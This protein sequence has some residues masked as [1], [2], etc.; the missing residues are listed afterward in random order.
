MDGD[1]RLDLFSWD[2]YRAVILALDPLVSQPAVV[3]KGQGARST[4][5]EELQMVGSYSGLFPIA[6]EVQRSESMAPLLS[7][8]LWPALHQRFA[9]NDNRTIWFT[10]TIWDMLAQISALDC[11]KT[12]VLIVNAAPVRHIDCHD[13]LRRPNKTGNN[14][15]RGCGHPGAQNCRRISASERALLREAVAD[16]CPLD[17]ARAAAYF[18][19]SHVKHCRRSIL[20]KVQGLHRQWT[21]VRDEPAITAYRYSCNYTNKVDGFA[22]PCVLLGQA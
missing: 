20:S 15:I 5:L 3:P 22:A 1:L 21:E 18:N 11:N 9:G 6:R 12:G 16:Y 8:R 17:D 14:C 2:L 19:C 7:A 4:D 10:N 13:L